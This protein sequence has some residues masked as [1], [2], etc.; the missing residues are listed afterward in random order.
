MVLS[1]IKEF[2]RDVVGL[3]PLLVL[4]GLGLASHVVSNL[5]LEKPITSAYG[6]VI[7][8]I[9]GTSIEAY[10]IWLQYRQIGL[11][12][13]GNDPV[14]MILARHAMDVVFILAAPTALV[15]YGIAEDLRH[16]SI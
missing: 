14:W 15:L 12:A 1:Q 3:P 13:P 9:L 4:V 8:L 10:E 6:L 2:L 7:P 16:G 11:L 5:L